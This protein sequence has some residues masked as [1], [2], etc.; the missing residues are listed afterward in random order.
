MLLSALLIAATVTVKAPPAPARAQA[1]AFVRIIQAA[2]VR[3][4]QSDTP[5]QRT[6][7]RDESGG[8]QILLQFE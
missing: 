2:E 7:R 4:G 5:H 3:D 6:M 1:Q 8:T